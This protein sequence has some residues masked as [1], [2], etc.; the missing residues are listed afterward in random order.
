M[1]TYHSSNRKRFTLRKSVLIPTLIMLMISALMMITVTYAWVS[2]TDTRK[3]NILEMGVDLTQ[4]V[5]ISANAVD[6]KSELTAEDIAAGY[7]G[8]KNVLSAN[9]IS[10]VSTACD[11]GN[12]G[13]YLEFYSG[14][15]D[16]GVTYLS[17]VPEPTTDTEYGQYYAYDVF[18]YAKAQS[19]L[20]LTANS[21]VTSRS[22]A[23]T[24]AKASNAA[25]V[26]FVNYGSSLVAEEALTLTTP[27]I[28]RFTG[29][30][31]VTIDEEFSRFIEYYVLEGGVYYHKTVFSMDYAQLVADGLYVKDT[32]AVLSEAPLRIW[33][34]NAAIHND[35]TT[36][37]REY[38]GVCAEGNL[39]TN[40]E[41]MTKSLPQ[42]VLFNDTANLYCASTTQVAALAAGYNKIRI[43]IWLE[44]QDEDSTDA[45]KGQTLV[46]NLDFS[47]N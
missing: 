34:P 37:V 25:R 12:D 17:K 8:S 36:G 5:F 15:A 45:I 20:Y 18:F 23:D 21:S 35:G 7:A 46:T 11:F 31:Q 3:A 29:Y 19:T 9:K 43:Y 22:N 13:K 32:D 14:Y 47:V 30:R 2:A 16:T 24:V 41:I 38:M 42:N 4:N 44:G 39:I 27:I 28:N 40:R 1:Q 26:A 6:L 10:T 33:E